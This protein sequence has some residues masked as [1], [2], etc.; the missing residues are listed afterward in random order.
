VRADVCGLDVLVYPKSLDLVLSPLFIE[1]DSGRSHDL[2]SALACSIKLHLEITEWVVSGASVVIELDEGH[3]AGGNDGYDRLRALL[4]FARDRN[5]ITGGTHY[6]N[7]A[8]ILLPQCASKGVRALILHQLR[9][10]LNV[11]VGC[12]LCNA[13]IKPYCSA[14]HTSAG[15]DGH[16]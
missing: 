11:L 7:A 12:V 16:T 3:V 1:A 5:L 13:E 8:F 10:V 9:E 4:P 6:T 14:A 15:A 2:T